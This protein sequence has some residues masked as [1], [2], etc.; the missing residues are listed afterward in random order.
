MPSWSRVH[1]YG[2]KTLGGDYVAGK[3]ITAL[4][5]T[6]VVAYGLHVDMKLIRNGYRKSGAFFV[7]LHLGLF[8]WGVTTLIMQ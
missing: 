4:M 3:V 1:R 6:G 8:I 2:K 5:L 7:V